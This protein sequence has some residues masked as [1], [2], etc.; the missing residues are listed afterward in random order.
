MQF[1]FVAIRMDIMG[2]ITH[3][4][5]IHLI[6][7]GQSFSRL[8]T[9]HILIV[10]LLTIDKD[11]TETVPQMYVIHLGAGEVDIPVGIMKK[12]GAEN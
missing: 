4:Q 12:D 11:V 6:H 3:L 1:L 9:N 2:I 8:V 10:V 5:W 7:L